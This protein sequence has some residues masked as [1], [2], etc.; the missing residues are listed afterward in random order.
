MNKAFIFIAGAVIG[1]VVT[2]KLVKTKYE[3]IANDEIESVKE[4]FRDIE[5]TVK[6]VVETCNNEGVN[7]DI[8]L[9]DKD[10]DKC[11]DIIDKN[12]YR[13]YSTKKDSDNKIEEKEEDEEMEGPY[14]ISPEEFNESEYEAETLTYYADGILTDL[15]DNII[16]EKDIDGLIGK[17]S[18]NHFGEFEDD[19]VFVRND[20]KEIDYE[21]LRDDDKYYS[22]YPSER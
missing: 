5:M 17:D 8:S 22:K 13:N 16:E 19:T 3:Q 9:K 4:R 18:L 2:W 1:S 12:G 6:D 10:I 21:I 11:N 7:V 20:E 15:Y 14:V